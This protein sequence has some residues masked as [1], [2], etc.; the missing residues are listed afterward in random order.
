METQILSD[1]MNQRSGLPPG[2]WARDARVFF[3]GAAVAAIFWGLF[4]VALTH[5]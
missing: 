3:R 2:G 4:F 5:L 1:K